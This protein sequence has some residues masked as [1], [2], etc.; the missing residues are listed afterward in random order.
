MRDVIYPSSYFIVLDI[1]G[2]IKNKKKYCEGG[3]EAE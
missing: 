3:R 2:I 1:E